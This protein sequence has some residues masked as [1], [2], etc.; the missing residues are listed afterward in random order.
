MSKSCRFSASLSA[1]GIVNLFSFTGS[2]EG[3]G[4]PRW[5]NGK[6]PACQSRRHK[7]CGFHPW[8]RKIPWSGKWQ[9]TPKFLPGKSHGQRSLAGCNPWGRKE[10]DTTEQGLFFA[11]VLGLLIIG[12]LL[13]WSTGSRAWA[14]WLCCSHAFRETNSLRRTMQIAE[15]SLLHWRAQ[16]RVSS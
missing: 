5:H 4:L 12:L 14:Q 1:F 9:L 6:E 2:S 7:R 16:G 13:L 8:L 3:M 11:A 15:C 10:L